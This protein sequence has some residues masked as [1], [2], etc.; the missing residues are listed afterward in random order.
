M[1]NFVQDGDTLSIPAPAGGVNGGGVVIVGSIVSVAV[2]DADENDPVEI[3][4]SGVF[5]L[6]KTASQVW[7]VGTKI[8]WTPGGIAT[9]TASGN[10]LIGVAVADAANPTDEGSVKIGP[11][12]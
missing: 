2:H 4:T 3:K 12:L 1:K 7:A 9:T 6:P 8:Y 11:V 10:P 5:S